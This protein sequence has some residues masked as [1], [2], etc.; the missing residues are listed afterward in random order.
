MPFA[1]HTLFP[2]GDLPAE[3]AVLAGDVLTAAYG[4]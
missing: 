3:E 1:R 2:I 4:G